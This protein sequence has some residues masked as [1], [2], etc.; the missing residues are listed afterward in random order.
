MISSFYEEM[1]SKKS[2]IRTLSEFSTE[3]GREIGYENVFDYTLGNPS[4]PTPEAFTNIL[5]RLLQTENP[6]KLHG[7]SPTL[8]IPAFK[9]AVAAFLR[10]RFGIPYQA[11]DIFP[12]I[13]AAGAVAHAL[14]CVTVPGDEVITFAPHFPEYTAYVNLTGA[15]LKV[16]PADTEHF[17][18]NFSELEKTISPKTMAVLINTPN[19]PSGAVYSRDTLQKLADLLHIKEKETGRLCAIPSPNPCRCR[20]NESAILLFSPLLENLPF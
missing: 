8:G 9:E 11:T 6:V 4:V 10:R 14:R 16:V 7:Y 5:I 19:N 1:L 3:R 17:Q 12:S 20:E 2:V 13:G 15:V 18:I